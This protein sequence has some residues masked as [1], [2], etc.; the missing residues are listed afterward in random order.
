MILSYGIKLKV[1]HRNWVQLHGDS[2]TMLKMKM[3][4]GIWTYEFEWFTC[5]RI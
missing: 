2:A 1:R 3:V 5:K 4:S